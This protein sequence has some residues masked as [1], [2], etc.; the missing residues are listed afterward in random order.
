M[1]ERLID[2]WVSSLF[3]LALIGAA[4]AWYKIVGDPVYAGVMAV[5]G[6][7]L[8]AKKERKD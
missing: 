7:G 4:L 6:V 3:G 5:A 2:S 8:I 1:K